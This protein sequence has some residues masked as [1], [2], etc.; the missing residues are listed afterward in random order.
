[1]F[2][3]STTSSLLALALALTYVCNILSSFWERMERMVTTEETRTANNDRCYLKNNNLVI[4]L[5]QLNSGQ[6]RITHLIN[7]SSTLLLPVT[8]KCQDL[9]LWFVDDVVWPVVKVGAG[10]GAACLS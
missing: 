9:N 3:I 2:S 6:E 1:M 5:T 4:L 7:T 10:P 8:R